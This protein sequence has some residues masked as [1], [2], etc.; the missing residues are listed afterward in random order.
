M[1]KSTPETN[2]ASVSEVRLREA[3]PRKYLPT[4]KNCRNMKG[5][6]KCSRKGTVKVTR[7]TSNLEFIFI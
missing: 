5:R 3:G 7:V 4:R 1:V 6:E 2:M